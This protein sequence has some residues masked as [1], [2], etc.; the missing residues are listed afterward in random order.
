MCAAQKKNQKFLKNIISELQ[1]AWTIYKNTQQTDAKERQELL[2][3]IH[4]IENLYYE[5]QTANKNM[6]KSIQ[7]LQ[8]KINDITVVK[9][10][11]DK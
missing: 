11:I 4:R 1:N 7:E 3:S 2:D 6:D 9:N 5:L 10:N 8:N